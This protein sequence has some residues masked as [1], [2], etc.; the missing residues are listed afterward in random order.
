MLKQLTIRNYA[1]IDEMT[2]VFRPGLNILTGE[3]GAGKSIILGA[4]GLIL[5]ERAR[6]DVIRQGASAAFV[7]AFFDVPTELFDDVLGP[8]QTG[9]SEGLLLRRE[10][11]D[12]GRSRCFVN[13]S[14]VTLNQMSLLGDRLVD[15][16]GRT[17]GFAEVRT[18][19]GISGQ[20][21]GG[22]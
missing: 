4:I 17:P 16:H 21:R 5:G 15:L 6:S 8:S 20:F 19:S 1:L 12:S 3:T 22:P 18:S 2:V 10:V 13:D 14:P 9:S 11:T 7:E